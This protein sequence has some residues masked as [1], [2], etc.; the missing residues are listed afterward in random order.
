MAELSEVRT[1]DFIKRAEPHYQKADDVGSLAY[2]N[3]SHALEVC[4]NAEY[5]VKTAR[6]KLGSQVNRSLLLVAA[7]WHDAA[8]H[9]PLDTNEFVTR[10]KR[11][12]TLAYDSLCPMPR[13][14]RANVVSAILDTEVNVSP[15]SSDL[16]VALHF[17]DVGYMAEGDY[18]RFCHNLSQMRLE[19]GQNDPSGVAPSWEATTERTVSFA[20]NLID[21]A[22][23]EL[24]RIFVDED[25]EAWIGRVNANVLRLKQGDHPK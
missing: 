10:E 5:V 2:H 19:W 6:K 3:W 1:N 21:E 4:R 18:D 8:Y 16:G 14:D 17:A 11:S 25:V 23:L 7:A 15:K 9:L 24:P 13:V 20:K 22:M 12:A